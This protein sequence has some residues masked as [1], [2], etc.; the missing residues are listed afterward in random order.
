MTTGEHAILNAPAVPIAPKRRLHLNL[1][2][3]CI[4]YTLAFFAVAVSRD[5]LVQIMPISGLLLAI[6]LPVGLAACVILFV[7]AMG[8]RAWLGAL[9]LIP[10]L[11]VGG[12][13]YR[14]VAF[15]RQPAQ[16]EIDISVLTL[17]TG[18][19]DALRDG[20]IAL[21]ETQPADVVLLQETF[22]LRGGPS[23]IESLMDRYPYQ[24]IQYN[25][26]GY[27]GNSTFSRIPILETQGFEPDNFYTRAVIDVEGR[28][29][30]VYN[31]SLATPFSNQNTDGVLG[32]ITSYDTSIR[33]QQIDQLLALVQNEPLPHIVA[34]DFNMNDLDP[35]YLR[36]TDQLGDSFAEVGIGAGLTWPASSISGLPAAT[37]LLLRLD[38]IF[39]SDELC[40][41]QAVTLPSTGSDHLP[42]WAGFVWCES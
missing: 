1:M 25:T 40:P 38:Y 41:V 21:L 11:L 12:S 32:L 2:T 33:N 24:Q 10:V 27:R 19:R 42:V 29:I 39:H 37:P 30:T 34:G 14:I 36:L 18:A 20:H 4:A 9:T 15:A 13:H 5:V 6:I 7:V 17:N 16:T 28:Q 31:I 8:G 35:A 22:Y 3:F 26:I 23:I